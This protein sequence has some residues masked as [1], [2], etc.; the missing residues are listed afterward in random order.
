MSSGLTLSMYMGGFRRRDVARS[1]LPSNGPGHV[2]ETLHVSTSTRPSGA[3]APP[4]GNR[5]SVCRG[6]CVAH[7]R[8]IRVERRASCRSL[9]REQDHRARASKSGID[10]IARRVVGTH[11][12]SDCDRDG[13]GSRGNS[14]ERRT[15]QLEGMNGDARLR[16]WDN[17]G[18]SRPLVFSPNLCAF[19]N[20]EGF[21][22]GLF[23]KP[24]FYRVRR[25]DRNRKR[26][27]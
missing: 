25:S 6:H 2:F 9:L 19:C 10:N 26:N 22:H 21:M 20:G 27:P 23:G 18:R 1:N 13:V 15:E 16:N 12:Y 11:H 4:L 5:V 24:Q 3:Q 17:N 7:S 8:R 14:Q